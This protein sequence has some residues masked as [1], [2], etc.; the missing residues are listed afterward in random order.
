MTSRY[1]S[2]SR[3]F[4]LIELI[5]ALAV[6]G[7]LSA[8]AYPAYRSW[9]NST[10]YKEAARRIVSTLRQ[11]RSQ[12]VATNLEC[13]A[14]F[15]LTT[16]QYRISRGDR[17]YNSNTFTA[18]NGW[19]GFSSS[20]D[21]RGNSD[22]SDNTTSNLMISFNPN[23]SSNTRYVCVVDDAGIN[24]YRVGIPLANTGRALIQHWN[25]GSSSW[26]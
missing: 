8:I 20:V 6:V 7:I 9:I 18:I 13:R 26:E 19:A 23:G 15:N 25:P 5:V 11:T 17:S 24:K 4:S 10:D 22:C 21:L 1:N 16:N 12:S 2:N 14:E 3:G